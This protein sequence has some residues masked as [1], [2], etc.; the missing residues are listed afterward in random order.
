MHIYVAFVASEVE[1]KRVDRSVRP[2]ETVEQEF[3]SK[4][5]E[6][7]DGKNV[8][9]WRESGKRWLDDVRLLCTGDAKWGGAVL[10][11]DD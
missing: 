4:E 6:E 11:G 3:K 2:S 9:V 5:C 10:G 8:M 1:V 7:L